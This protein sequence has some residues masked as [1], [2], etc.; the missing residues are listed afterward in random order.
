MRDC[1]KINTPNIFSDAKMRHKSKTEFKSKQMN[2][3]NNESLFKVQY[4]R[5]LEIFK[6]VL[7]FCIFCANNYVILI[8]FAN[9]QRFIY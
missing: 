7:R 5:I 9:H 8:R 1:H 3:N 4:V 2:M 6:I